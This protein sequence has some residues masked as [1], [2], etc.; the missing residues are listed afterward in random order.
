[1]KAVGSLEPR[2]VTVLMERCGFTED[3]KSVTQDV[4]ADKL[5]LTQERIRQL[6]NQALRKLR[7]YFNE[8]PLDT[9]LSRKRGYFS[10]YLFRL[11]NKASEELRLHG[12]KMSA[13]EREEIKNKLKI[14]EMKWKEENNMN[15]IKDL[16]RNYE[17]KLN[18]TSKLEIYEVGDLGVFLQDRDPGLIR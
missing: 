10:D 3:G 14:Y 11:F 17:R 18:N 15:E 16:E 7:G 12:Y 1:M 6:E 13:E 5:G 8:Y 4:L 9:L 2:L